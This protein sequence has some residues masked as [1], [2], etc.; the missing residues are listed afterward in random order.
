MTNSPYYIDL[1]FSSLFLI[2]YYN[3]LSYDFFFFVLSRTDESFNESLLHPRWS[4]P[5]AN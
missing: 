5:E 1:R 4:L 2:L 3:N